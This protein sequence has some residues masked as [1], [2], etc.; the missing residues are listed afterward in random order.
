[1]RINDK[2]ESLST[3]IVLLP[4]NPLPFATS[5]ILDRIRITKK[6]T[7]NPYKLASLILRSL[8]FCTFK[9]AYL[10][11]TIISTRPAIMPT[12]TCFTAFGQSQYQHFP[13]ILPE[14]FI[15]IVP[16]LFLIPAL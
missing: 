8:V 12:V 14:I 13:L 15:M 7:F 11:C 4:E 10:P 9:L 16:H 6:V 3:I 1:M 2:N 5:Q